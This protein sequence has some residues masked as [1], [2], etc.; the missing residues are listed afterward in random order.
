[1]R[2]PLAL[3]SPESAVMHEPSREVFRRL[4]GLVT[5]TKN[6]PN[7]LLNSFFP[8]TVRTQLKAA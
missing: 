3:S 4:Y 1:M 6:F 2:R 5:M 7:F 8:D